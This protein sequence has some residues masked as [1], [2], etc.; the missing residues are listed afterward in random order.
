MTEATQSVSR[1]A[2]YLARN[3]AALIKAGQEVLATLGPNATIEQLADHA[4]VSTTTIYK[5]FENKEV[6]FAEALATI[7][8]EWVA[9]SYG[10]STPG[11]SLEAS[12]RSARKLFWLR[13]THPDFAQIMKN[14]MVNPSFVIKAVKDDGVAVFTTL[15]DR[16]EIESQDF[17]KRMVLWAYCLAGLLT[18]VYVTEELSPKDAE[19]ALGLG[20]SI[21][22]VSEQTAQKLL[23]TPLTLA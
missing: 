19:T 16:G 18:S 8:G 5:Y 3:R 2:A 12:I 15:A 21:W 1:Q 4:Q 17:N 10:E 11:E 9:W 6:L 22:G 20:L 13:Q 23:A 14:V 7:W